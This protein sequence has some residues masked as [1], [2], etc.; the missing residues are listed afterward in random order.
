MNKYVGK[1]F[2]ITGKLRSL[3]LKIIRIFMSE[4]FLQI[5]PTLFFFPTILL[6]QGYYYLEI[7][8]IRISMN[9]SK[10]LILISLILNHHTV[11]VKQWSWFLL[12]NGFQ[13]RVH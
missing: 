7:S 12:N 5:V 8:I 9:T 3:N 10:H 6:N 4:R 11:P 13:R 2:V 1:E